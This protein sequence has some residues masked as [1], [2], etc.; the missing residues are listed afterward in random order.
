MAAARRQKASTRSTSRRWRPKTS[1]AGSANATCCWDRRGRSPGLKFAAMRRRGRRRRADR[2]RWPR[3]RRNGRRSFL[4]ARMNFDLV[5]DLREGGHHSGNWG[6]CSRTLHHPRARSPRSAATRRDQDPGM[7][8]EPCRIRCVW[9]PRTAGRRWRGA[10]TTQVGRAVSPQREGVGWQFRGAG[11]TTG[12]P[13]NRST[14]SRPRRATCQIR[15]SRRRPEDPCRRCAVTSTRRFRY[16]GRV[17]ESLFPATRLDPDHDWVRWAAPRSLKPRARPAI[18][19]NLGGSL[20]ND[21]FAN[22]LGL[23]IWPH[24]RLVLQHPNEDVCPVTARA[25]GMTGPLGP[26]R[27]R[28]LRGFDIR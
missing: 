19:P 10:Q 13:E 5:V 15:L 14:R 17:E 24:L 21:I 6:G 7:E 12:N 1:A 18:L 11:A 2:P 25:R 9:R 28:R 22:D 3:S 4:A 26:R 20:P 8:A 16:P 27:K 23:T